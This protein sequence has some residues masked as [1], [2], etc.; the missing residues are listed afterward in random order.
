MTRRKPLEAPPGLLAHHVAV[1]LD[2]EIL[3]RVDAL[4][5]RY[6]Q[7][8]RKATR[9]DLLRVLVLAGLDALGAPP[10]RKRGR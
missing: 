3:A 10:R 8:W 1:R 4:E 7:P 6:S 2:A 9:S 5:P